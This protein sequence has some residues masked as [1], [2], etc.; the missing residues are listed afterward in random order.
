MSI[1]FARDDKCE[2]PSGEIVLAA[3]DGQSSARVTST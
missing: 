3:G 2:S 1:A